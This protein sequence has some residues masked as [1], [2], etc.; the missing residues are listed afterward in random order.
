MNTRLSNTEECV[1]YLENRILEITQSEQQKE[2]QIK[3]KNEDSLR[4]LFDNIKCTNICIIQV[5]KGEQIEKEIKNVFEEIMAPN[6]PNLKRERYPGA[7]ITDGPKQN[8]PNATHTKTYQ[9]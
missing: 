7:G 9:N 3:K 1:S 5:P 6:F 2:K 8:E 4:D